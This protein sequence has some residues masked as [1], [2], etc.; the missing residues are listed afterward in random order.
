[1]LLSSIGFCA[2]LLIVFPR[3]TVGV[4][5]FVVYFSSENVF[6]NFDNLF[7]KV[8]VDNSVVYVVEV[9]ALCNEFLPDCFSEFPFNVYVVFCVYDIIL[10]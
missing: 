1:M 7:S 10:V 8:C 6:C 4:D 5:F 9:F 2:R 3:S